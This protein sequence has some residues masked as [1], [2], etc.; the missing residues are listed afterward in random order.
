MWIDE[1]HT[2]VDPP[3]RRVR[4]AG[5][6]E[7]MPVD[8]ANVPHDAPS[9]SG[10]TAA[11][12]QEIPTENGRVVFIG[13]VGVNVDVVEEFLDV[14]LHVLQHLLVG[15]KRR[16]VDDG[17]AGNG[18]AAPPQVDA[19][20]PPSARIV[21]D[22]RRDDLDT[23]RARRLERVVDPFER[24]RVE[25]SKRG[26]EAL[27]ASDR[28]PHGLTADYRNPHLPGGRH[29]VV[30]LVVTRKVRAIRIEW[31]VADQAQPF[32]VRAPEAERAA[33]DIEAWPRSD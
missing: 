23:P 26:L 27:I 10:R 12:V 31:P 4:G 6:D 32:D 7:V 24:G 1:A 19:A 14:I 28:V 16:H 8:A 13:D 11:P 3:D 25:M 9:P 18:N 15:P 29:C 5:E 22:D 30:D 33:G 20:R 2:Q 21:A 17:A